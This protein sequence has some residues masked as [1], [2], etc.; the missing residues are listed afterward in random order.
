MIEEN[1]RIVKYEIDEKTAMALKRIT[2]KINDVDMKVKYG[3]KF[4]I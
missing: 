3:L 4:N 2:G 1:K